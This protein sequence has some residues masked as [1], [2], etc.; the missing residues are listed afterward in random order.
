MNPDPVTWTSAAW[1]TP[2][3]LTELRAFVAPEFGDQVELVEVRRRPWSAVWRVSVGDRA[4][5]VK[6]N[7]PGQQHEAGLV[8]RLA[9]IAPD[10]LVPVLAVDA[11]RDLLLTPDL[12]A[13]L[14]DTGLAEERLWSRIVRDGALLQRAVTPYAAGFGLARITADVATTYV[15]DAVGRLAALPG[16]DPRRLDAEDAQRLRRL[17]PTLGRW[18][19]EVA[20]L[21]LP[22]TINHNDLH[23][24]NVFAPTD[25]ERPLRFFDFGDAVLTDPLAGLLIP[26]QVL[27]S[28]WACAADDR[29]LVRVADAALEVWSD[30][31]PLPR[32]RAALP[33]ALQIGRLA[34]VESWRRCIATMTQAERAEFG[35][36]AAGWLTSLTAPPPYRVPSPM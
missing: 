2:E 36:A 12:G 25:A 6:Q 22:A 18:A 8:R 32:L 33:A 31:V 17:L 16:G 5:Y 23:A 28:E 10:Y 35:G 29:R 34:R 9:D 20:E 7:C 13:T 14:G 21:D 30:L 24:D 11:G 4:G 27:A 1:R 26:L 15:A 19:D 3:F